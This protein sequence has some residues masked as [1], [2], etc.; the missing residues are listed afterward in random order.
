MPDV[1]WNGKR[2]GVNYKWPDSGEL[3][4]EPWGNSEAHWFGSLYPRLHR[5]LPAKSV[6][7]IAPGFGR[8]TK[9]LLSACDSYLG[10]DL[11]E[12]C[13]EA[14]RAR[15]SGAPYARFASNDG[16]NLDAAKDG[17]IDFVFSF[18]SLVHVEKDVLESYLPQIV[19]KLAPGGVA[20]IHHSNLLPLL[21]QTTSKRNFHSRARTVSADIVANLI[22][23]AGGIVLVQEV[24]N[25]R[26]PNLIDALTTFGRASDFPDRTTTRLTNPRFMEEAALIKDYQ[27]PYTTLMEQR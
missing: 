22:E 7:E 10:I 4:S 18:D 8:W 6:L 23:A 14:C 25:W 15:F 1:A 3:W 17:T 16:Y 24:I 26:D 12:Q 27:H 5:L 13:A 2:W 20:F 9:F 11:A 21:L 19:R